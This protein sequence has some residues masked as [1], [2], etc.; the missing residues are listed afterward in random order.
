MS[1]EF[2]SVVLSRQEAEA[3]VAASE[4]ADNGHRTEDERAAAA[5]A[6]VLRYA[7]ANERAGASK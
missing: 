6:D 1:T 3:L 5:G 4:E 2:I 7:L